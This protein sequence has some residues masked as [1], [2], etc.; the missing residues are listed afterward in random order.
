VIG[1]P[2]DALFEEMA[3]LAERF[4]WSRDEL[5]DLTHHERRR[6]LHEV[7]RLTARE[8]ARSLA[9]QEQPWP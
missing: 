7:D 1:H 6:W 5:M 9:E 4:H 2:A 3:E 8:R